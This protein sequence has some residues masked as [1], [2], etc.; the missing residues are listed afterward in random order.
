MTLTD[1]HCPA[2]G[3][4]LFKAD[5][6]ALR[7]PNEHATST[8]QVEATA[9]AIA[10]FLDGQDHVRRSPYGKALQGEVITSLNTWLRSRGDAELSRKAVGRGMR[11]LGFDVAKSQ[12]QRFYRGLAVVAT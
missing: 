4:H 1:I 10:A 8:A 5:L 11:A 9:A 2:C 12:G 7:A 3:H 6:G